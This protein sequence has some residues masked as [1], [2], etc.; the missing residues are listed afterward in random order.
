[1]SK[2]QTFCVDSHFGDEKIDDFRVAEARRF[3]KQ[4]GGDFLE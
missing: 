3:P 1:M 4:A 2:S